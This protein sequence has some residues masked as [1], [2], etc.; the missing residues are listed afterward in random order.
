MG[1]DIAELEEMYSTDQHVRKQFLRSL[2]MSITRGEYEDLKKQIAL[3]LERPRLAMTV[4]AA[5]Q[6]KCCRI[7]CGPDSP[8]GPGN[9]FVL[10]YGEEYAHEKC[11]ERIKN[12]EIGVV[13]P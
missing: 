5:Q 13:V 1:M 9:S 8:S 3:L 11:L 4:K 6:N 10:R 2:P 7:C 12:A